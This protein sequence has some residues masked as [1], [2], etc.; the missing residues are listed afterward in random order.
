MQCKRRHWIYDVARYLLTFEVALLA[1][2]RAFFSHSKV[3]FSP[4]TSAV[5][6][7]TSRT[8]WSIHSFLAFFAFLLP[9]LLLIYVY[10][11]YS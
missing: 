5:C 7:T 1:R 9:S 10:V 6:Q 2:A 4:E 8:S 11:D 3:T